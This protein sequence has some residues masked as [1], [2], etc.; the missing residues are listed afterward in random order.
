MLFLAEESNTISSLKVTKK[1]AIFLML[2]CTLFTSAGQIFWK[3]GLKD[4]SFNNLISF[5][6][7]LFISGCLFYGIGGLLMLVAFKYAEL[8]V[9]Y[10]IIATSYIWVSLASPLIFLNDKM[11]GW[12][13]AGVVLILISLSVLGYGASKKGED[14]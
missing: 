14:N 7:V 9:L 6:N 5:V 4:V 8:S 13:W 2:L 1:G 3:L 11:N 12:K 10:P